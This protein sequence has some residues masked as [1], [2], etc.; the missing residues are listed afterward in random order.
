MSGF[1]DIGTKLSRIYCRYMYK[2]MSGVAGIVQNI[3]C[4]CRTNR[5]ELFH[6]SASTHACAMFCPLHLTSAS[7]LIHAVVY[8]SVAFS[9]SPFLCIV[10]SA[11]LDLCPF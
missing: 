7:T 3:V 11:M 4:F 10:L 8:S 6:I 2:T 9:A 5:S 1:A